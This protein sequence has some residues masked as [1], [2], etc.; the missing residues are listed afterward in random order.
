MKLLI[1][2]L[3]PIAIIAVAVYILINSA[4]KEAMVEPVRLDLAIDAVSGNVSIFSATE[5]ILKSEAKGRVT[6]TIAPPNSGPVSVSEG[7]III[8][9]DTTDTEREIELVQIKLDAAERRLAS[10]S[11]FDATIADA[12]AKLE[13]EEELAANDQFPEADLNKSR[14][15]VASLQLQREQ[16]K[17]VREELIEVLKNDLAR[18][19]DR[20]SRLSIISPIDGFVTE[21]L[22]PVGDLVFDGHS[23]A[24]V[25]SKERIVEVSLSEEDFSGIEVGQLV[26]VRL[27][28]QGNQLFIGKVETILAEANPQTRRRSIYVSLDAPNDTM[29]PGTT[30]QASITKAE[31]HSALVVPRRALVG[32]TVYV[33]SNGRVIARQ[34]EVG[35]SG[36]H[37]AEVISGIK[38][39]DMVIVETPHLFR[40]GDQVTAIG[41]EDRN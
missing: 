36:I 35:F 6:E 18:L 5:L 23:V 15:A 21:I 17:I 34:V 33:V 14:R 27:L 22:A 40:D 12:E 29:T 38:E 1:K 11:A 8:Q 13:V 20:L 10:G 2:I 31:R 24:K 30:G 41:P 39:G 3:I 32:N 28:S 37:L 26:T 7:D 25:I 16:E 9:L 19:E 4:Q